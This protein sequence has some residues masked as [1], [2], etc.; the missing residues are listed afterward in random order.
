LFSVEINEELLVLDKKYG[1]GVILL[2]DQISKHIQ[3]AKPNFLPID[4]ISELAQK[5]CLSV[6]TKWNTEL[7]PNEF[8]FVMLVF[9]HK[10]TFL[11][12][13]FVIQETWLRLKT[14]DKTVQPIYKRFLRATYERAIV[15][16]QNTQPIKYC[17]S[18]QSGDVDSKFD[19]L[20]KTH[21]SILDEKCFQKLKSLPTS[22]KSLI[23]KIKSELAK[24]SNEKFILS[25]SGGVDSMICS[26]ILSVNKIDF[27]CVHINY[28]NRPESD[29]EEQFVIDWCNL[30][31]VDLY[32]RKIDEINRP[33]CMEWELRDL[34]ENYTRNV[35]YLTY[36]K[37]SE[38]KS[39][40]V[41][42]AHNQDDCFEN[43]LTNIS[44][45]SKYDNLTGME[46]NS[47]TNFLGHVINFIRP[48]LSITKSEIYQF[49]HTIKIP[50]LWDST[51]KWSQ[52]G[53]IRDEVRPVLEKWNNN[54]I[55]GFFELSV[56]AKESNK[57]VELYVNEWIKKIVDMTIVMSI[58]E[59]PIT[60]LFWKLL[61]EKLKF[62]CSPQSLEGL[63]NFLVRFS[64][65]KI[66]QDINA[67]IKYQLNKYTQIKLILLVDECVKLSFCNST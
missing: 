48:M 66:K 1:V 22:K 36:L 3:R 12:V 20:I 64:N 40:Q 54:L 39:N 47:E 56:Q 26:W 25:I 59:L 42:L 17:P 44:K 13:K 10:K 41:I 16:T 50:F 60:K 15:Q 62:K 57:I 6:Y 35:R 31:N 14:C 67:E 32:V 33:E 51:P 43:I 55:E 46:F 5:Y 18:L 38:H 11:D 19:Q 23:Q 29:E 61:L 30:L 58:P 7:T 53:K 28:F 63:I 4:S 34:Y 37:V 2:Y 45:K 52:R 21:S 27:C 8:C 24:L 9:R 65:K 49:A